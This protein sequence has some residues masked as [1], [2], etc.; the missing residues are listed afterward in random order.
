M[1]IER[2]NPRNIRLRGTFRM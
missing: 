2:L 1:P